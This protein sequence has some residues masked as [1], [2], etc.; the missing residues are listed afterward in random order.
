MTF[1]PRVVLRY[2]TGPFSGLRQIVGTVADLSQTGELPNPLTGVQLSDGRTL[3][4]HLDA[5]PHPH[6]VCYSEQEVDA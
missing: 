4:M 5:P 2:T 3:T 6:Y 1:V